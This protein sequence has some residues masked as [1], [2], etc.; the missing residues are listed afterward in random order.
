MLIPLGITVFD[1]LPVLGT[2][3][4]LIPWAVVILVSMVKNGAIH[5][6]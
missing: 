3:G 1:I 4:I 5:M 6:S 2:G